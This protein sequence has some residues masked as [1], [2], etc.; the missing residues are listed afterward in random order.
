MAGEG[1]ATG[2]EFDIGHGIV[3]VN[4]DSGYIAVRISGLEDFQGADLTDS[5]Y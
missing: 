2:A 3:R 5:G 1:A 4:G